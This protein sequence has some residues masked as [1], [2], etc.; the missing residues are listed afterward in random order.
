MDHPN[1]MC[2]F[3]T[4]ITKSYEEIA[5]DLVNWVAGTGNSELNSLLDLFAEDLLS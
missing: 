5:D 3:E 2:T 4:V 1:G